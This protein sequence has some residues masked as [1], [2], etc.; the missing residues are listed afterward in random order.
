VPEL[1]EVE[2]IRRILF[3]GTSEVPS[4]IGQTIS[5]VSLFWS[6]TLATPTPEVFAAFLK[7]K[8]ITA[9]DRRGKYLIL[10]LNEGYLIFHLRM[11]GDLQ[12][13]HEIGSSRLSDPLQPHDRSYLHFQS[14]WGLAFND[15]R[16]F[17]RMWLTPDTQSVLSNLGPEPFDPSL[18]TDRFHNMLRASKRQLKALLLDQHFL[19]G[20]GNIYTDEALFL[21]GL[22]PRRLSHTV[23]PSEAETLLKSIREVLEFGITNNGASIDW[24]YRGGNFQNHFNVYQQTG[25]PCPTCGTPIERTIVAQRGT[26]YCPHCQP[27]IERED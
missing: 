19:A 22:N 2:T 23:S 1:P 17:G 9:L 8:S 20:L 4:L 5:D 21:A 3:N 14:G 10:V 7:G 6:R 15:T 25:N 12:T 13:A 11:S 18:S 27:L 26:H 24:V 16:K